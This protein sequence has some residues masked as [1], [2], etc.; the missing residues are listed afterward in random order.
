MNKKEL[1]RKLCKA[2]KGKNQVNIA[3]MTEIVRRLG[4]M[5]RKDLSV[6]L[7]ILRKSQK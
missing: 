2:E 4:A 3:Q 1:A 5:A 6:L 7:T